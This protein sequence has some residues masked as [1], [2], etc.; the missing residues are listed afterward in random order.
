MDAIQEQGLGEMVWD[1]FCKKE[2]IAS[3]VFTLKQCGHKTSYAQVARFVKN[4]VREMSDESH[5]PSDKEPESKRT[6]DLITSVS[7]KN[8]CMKGTS[9]AKALAYVPAFREKFV[10]EW[11]TALYD[12]MDDLKELD[13]LAVEI[14][15]Q[16]FRWVS[17]DID[18]MKVQRQEREV[19]LKAVETKLKFS[20]ELKSQTGTRIVVNQKPD[21]DGEGK[22]RKVLLFKVKKDA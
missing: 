22:D 14:L 9:R 7:L 16:C 20:K 2:P 10:K 18:W 3:I 19:A 6:L 11:A 4:R 21:G 17:A 5:A 1:M 15:L 13:K 8:A 12:R